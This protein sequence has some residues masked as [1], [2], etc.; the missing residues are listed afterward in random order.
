[1]NPHF[2]PKA[3]DKDMGNHQGWHQPCEGAP[4][5]KADQLEENA[6][7]RKK[8]KDCWELFHGCVGLL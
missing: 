6:N 5:V 7:D 1:M 3:T 4:F 8:M 2:A